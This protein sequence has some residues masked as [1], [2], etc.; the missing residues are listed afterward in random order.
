MQVAKNL[1][2]IHLYRELYICYG[3]KTARCHI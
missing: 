1:I 3:Y 2:I